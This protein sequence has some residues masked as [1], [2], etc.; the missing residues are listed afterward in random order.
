ML[1]PPLSDGVEDATLRAPLPFRVIPV[2]V[3]AVGTVA[4]GVPVID[5]LA[6][7][8][9]LALRAFNKIV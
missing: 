9:P 6:A 1:E 8:V 3:G 4:V 5:A 7:L 2:I